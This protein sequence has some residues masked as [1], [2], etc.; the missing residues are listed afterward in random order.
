VS[1]IGYAAALNIEDGENSGDPSDYVS[2][3]ELQQESN[4]SSQ[5]QPSF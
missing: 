3:A 1:D 2:T 5:D 4:Y